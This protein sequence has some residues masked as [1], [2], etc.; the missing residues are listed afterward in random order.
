MAQSDRIFLA[1]TDRDEAITGNAQIDEVLACRQCT[2]LAQGEIV[3][4]RAPLVAVSLDLDHCSR[5]A[6][7]YARVGLKDVQRV[8]A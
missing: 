4:L 2:L 7:N 3:F 1:I 8:L 5:S 6:L